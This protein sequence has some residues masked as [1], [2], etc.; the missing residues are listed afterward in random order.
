MNRTRCFSTIIVLVGGLFAALARAQTTDVVEGEYLVKMKSSASASVR[1]KVS[2]KAFVKAQFSKESYHI[3]AT[4]P[5]VIDELKADADVEYVEPNY[6]LQSIEPTVNA[7]NLSAQSAAYYDQTGA[8]VHATEAWSASS[9]YDSNNR[10]IVA[11]VDTGLDSSHYVFRDTNALWVNPG[12]IPANGIDDEGNGYVDDVNGWNFIASGAN[13]MDDED[14]GTHVAGIVLGATQDILAHP[15]QP[16]K[17]RIMPLKFLD[18]SGAGST[19]AAI[20]AINY[21]VNNGAKVINC[22]WGGGA[23]S[24]A[25]HDALTSAYNHGVLIV[26]AAGNYSTN[27]DT[28]PLYPASYNVPSNISV[29]ASTDGD[30]LASFSNYGASTVHVASPGVYVYSTMPGNYFASLSGT[31]MAAPFVAGAAAMALREAPQL[32]GYQLRAEI[33]QTATSSGYLS[34][35]VQSGGRID[36]LALM[37][38][39]SGMVSTASF[40]PDYVPSY[41]AERSPASESKSGGGCGLVRAI[42]DQGGGPGSPGASGVLAVLF[43]L[44]LLLW[45]ALRG[46]TPLPQR[47]YDRY[48]LRSEVVIRSGERELVGQMNTISL[49]GLSFNVDEALEKG[50]TVKMMIAGPNVGQAVEVE[51]R[52]VW[53]ERNKAYGVQFQ[54]VETPVRETLFGWT[55]GLVRQGFRR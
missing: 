2:G 52:I 41:S 30:R 35:K 10:P 47:K 45:L 23:Y 21:A 12:E 46:Q 27:N 15:L 50:C 48:V 13:F 53:S 28:S 49:G 31:S 37:S 36:V 43:G 9:P 11:I 4:D 26:S 14:H 20:N 44:P 55:R 54:D 38:G 3:V 24:H 32:S 5:S 40:Q 6:K 7:Q 16:A 33:M 51:G 8:P 22:S 39:V 34:G 25:L 17:I 19:S 18:S 1:A 29:A 42:S